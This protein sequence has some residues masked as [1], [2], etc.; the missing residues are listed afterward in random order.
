MPR[1]SFTL[2]TALFYILASWSGAVNSADI[3]LL[4]SDNSSAYNEFVSHIEQHNND[5]DIHY[6]LLQPDADLNTLSST[7]APGSMLVTIGTLALHK[8][9]QNLP[10]LPIISV[11]ITRSAF[12][13]FIRDQPG[14]SNLVSNGKLS[15]LFLEQPAYRYLYLASALSPEAKRI[16]T[17]TG[18]L[19]SELLHQLKPLSQD[20]GLQLSHEVIDVRDNPTRPIDKV[21]R[22]S[23]VY[24]ALPD[25][26]LFNS[27]TAKWVL[28]TGLK[29]RVPIVG[30]SSRYAEAGAVAAIYTTPMDASMET[31]EWI[32]QCVMDRSKK[33]S[34]PRY[35]DSYTLTVN[36]NVAEKLGLPALDEEQLKQTIKRMEERK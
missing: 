19:S 33:L 18:P 6:K 31:A 10:R 16:G 26:S 15:A 35:P 29:W 28:L 1:Y 20:L 3:F 2:L 17:V 9:I 13:T 30:F 11:L 34:A 7:T 14:L 36:H 12:E 4:P 24:L 25:S 8:A 21:M 23:D 5:P 32:R 22:N 27:G